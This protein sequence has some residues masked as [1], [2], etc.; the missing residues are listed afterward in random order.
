MSISSKELKEWLDVS[1]QKSQSIDMP[2]SL[3][4][5]KCTF[6]QKA[7]AI[8]FYS[9]RKLSF[10]SLGKLGEPLYSHCK[11][12]EKAEAQETLKNQRGQL[13]LVLPADNEEGGV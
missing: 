4:T 12:L 2:S 6:C 7:C 5:I 13:S 3:Y 10:A 9:Q 11:K 1:I 8:T